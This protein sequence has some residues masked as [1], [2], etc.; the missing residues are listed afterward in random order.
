MVYDISPSVGFIGLGRMGKPMA[1]NLLRLG[2]HVVVHSRTKESMTEVTAAGAHPASYAGEVAA[3]A[4]IV[5]TCLPDE[6]ACELVYLGES[7]LIEG[8]RSS[9]LFVETSTISPSLAQKIAHVVVQKGASYLDAPISGGVGGAQ[10]AT[11]TI[12]VGGEARDLDRA[13][14]FLLQMGKSIHHIG[15]VGMGEVVKLVNQLLVAVH[16]QAACEA[17]MLAIKA[18]VNPHQVLDVLS[19]SWG[20]SAMLNR[21]GPMIANDDYGSAAP[22]RLIAKDIGLVTNLAWE[23]GVTLS[24]ANES[25]KVIEL[26]MENGLA[27]TDVAALATL[28]Q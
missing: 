13:R 1:L 27:E 11:L 18:G 17:M 23:N 16:T 24:L 7:G 9:N 15:G 4:D 20:N 22:M 14:P 28:M 26:A 2:T 19:T 25:R 12:M 6:A 3:L 21:A 8:C 10:D 5:F